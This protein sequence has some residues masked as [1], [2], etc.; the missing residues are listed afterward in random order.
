MS[1]EKAKKLGVPVL[2]TIE[3]VGSAGVPPQLM[4]IGPAL[5]IPKAIANSG[6]NPNS[7]A[8]YELNEAFASQALYCI[9]ELGLDMDK[10]NVNGGA[11]ALGHPLGATGARLV[12]TLV[13][14]LGRRG[15]GNGVV[16]MCVGTGMGM[17]MVLR[18][19]GLFLAS[20]L[21]A[22]THALV[23][24]AEYNY[25]QYL[26]DFNKEACPRAEKLFSQRLSEALEF[27]SNP[28]RSYTKGINEF[29]DQV[30]PPLGRKTSGEVA[31]QKNLASSFKRS[32]EIEE[33]PTSVDWRTA[34]VV[35]PVKN[36]G[37]C[38]S[39]WA[40]A[41]TATVESHIALETGL[42]FSLSPQQLVACAPNTDH[43]GGVGGCMGSIPELAYD[44]LIGAGGY[45]E[46]WSF[47]YISYNG[48]TN[49]TCPATEDLQVKAGISGYIKL[50]E[51]NAADVMAALATVGPLAVNVDASNWH[52]Y[53]SGVYDG[54]SY[55]EMDIDHVVVLV[56]YGVDEETKTPYWLIRNSWSPTFGEAGYIRLLREAPEDTKCGVDTSPQDGTGCDGAATQYPCGQCGV[57]F[58]VSYPTGA[59]LA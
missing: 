18:M 7:I 14:E 58:D 36:Q 35:T 42:L 9:K 31:S 53:E 57:V 34:G 59:F 22:A 56:G 15:G 29:S 38:G 8:L 23:P 54:C 37:Q 26:N 48:A 24:T 52:N 49:G 3:G 6:V 46:E 55:E 11:I 17:A 21:T 19:K 2:A 45:A 13:S 33:L 39:C 16:S 44:Y 40:F 47:P 5:A 10:V 28:Q 20:L 30:A 27:N 51:N 12:V 50:E 32:I 43:C 41:T 25:E 1:V 4:G